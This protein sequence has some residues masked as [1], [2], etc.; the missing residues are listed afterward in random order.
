MDFEI[1]KNIIADCNSNDVKLRIVD[2]HLK[3][4]AK[5]KLSDNLLSNI[6]RYKNDLKEYLSTNPSDYISIPTIKN[7]KDYAL[8]SAQRR[9]WVLSRFDGANEAYN[10][11]QVV[12]LVGEVNE[13]AFSTAYHDLLT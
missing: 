3:I 13:T 10:I 9:L 1:L 8:S 2:G 4:F 5:S 7:T 12:R 6:K 11:P